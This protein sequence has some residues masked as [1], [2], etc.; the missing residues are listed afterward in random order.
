MRLWLGL[1][2][3][4]LTGCQP[5]PSGSL[6]PAFYHWKTQFA[7]AP[8]EVQ[9]LDSL[10]VRR[11]YVKFFDLAWDERAQAPQPTAFV[12]LPQPFS[13][14]YEL[15]PTVFI[16]QQV[17]LRLPIQRVDG[18]A[19]RVA[20]KLLEMGTDAQLPPFREVQMD[21]DWTDSTREAYFRFLQT[22]GDL[23]QEH[24]VRLSAT[25]R[26][27][28]AKTPQKSGVPPV[29]RGMLMVYNVGDVK[30]W[31][32]PNSILNIE[33]AKPYLSRLQT[34][35]LPLDL[36]LPLF[37]WG[38]LFREGEMIRLLNNLDAEQLT[39]RTRFFPMTA[40][41]YEVQQNTFLDGTFLYQGDFIRLEAVDTALLHQVMDLLADY[42][43][44]ADGYL[45]YYHLDSA[46]VAG[47]DYGMLERVNA[48]LRQG[49]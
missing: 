48:R 1:F 23:L 16:T 18:L 24:Q 3:V 40:Q 25:I 37:R 12:E 13:Y 46:V 19:Q 6:S 21:C 30:Q 9:L 35:P 32:E 49:D 15:V 4:L 17:F 28:Q 5:T 38:V 8:S 14:D 2:L 47:F 10:A 7:P 20:D 29:D 39:D 33:K 31:E 45:S 34:Y 43:W 26:L 11:L 44:P 42:P 27:Y 41:R 36:A 22:L